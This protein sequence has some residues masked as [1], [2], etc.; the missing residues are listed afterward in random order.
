MRL[1]FL[2]FS[3]ENKNEF[4]FLAVVL[5]LVLVI[6]LKLNLE[7]T[8]SKVVTTFDIDTTESGHT[9]EF[10]TKKYLKKNKKIVARVKIK[11]T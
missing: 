5:V 7:T 11:I 4:S 10:C 1:L 6:F 8:P 3:S 2:L 9:G